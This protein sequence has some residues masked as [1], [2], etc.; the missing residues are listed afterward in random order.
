M[1]D[2][3]IIATRNS[4]KIAEISKILSEIFPKMNILSLKDLDLEDPIEDGKTFVENAFIKAKHYYNIFHNPIITDDSG[5]S[6]NALN[7]MP[8]IYSKR[9]S[10]E[11]TD[12][13][14]N[15]KMINEM[16]NKENR[17]AYF[18]CA[19]CLYIN[20]HCYYFF[21][22]HL[23]GEVAHKIKGENGF[24]YDAILYL[25]HYKKNLAQLDS[26]IKSQISHR[27]MAL[28]KMKKQLEEEVKYGK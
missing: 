10:T 3:I 20:P 18:T 4:H 17:F 11:G 21:E 7:N 6:V 15:L 24:G 16:K 5:I 12:I 28:E 25:S 27:R 13:A 23:S 2:N 8:G 22:G 19:I 9:Y 26:N 14:N 1:I